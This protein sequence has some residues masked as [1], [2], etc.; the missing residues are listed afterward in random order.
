M[1]AMTFQL[2][3]VSITYGHLPTLVEV[4]LSFNGSNTVLFEG[5]TGAGKTTLVQLLTASVVPIHGV[6]LINGIPTSR[7]QPKAR[8]MFRRTLGIVPQ[9]IHL[10]ETL[11]ITQNVLAALTIRGVPKADAQRRTLEILAEFH[12]SHLREQRPQHLSGGERQLATIAVA[13]APEPK[14]LFADEPLSMLDASV[15][16]TVVHAIERR[17]SNG[18]GAVISTHDAIWS[19]AFPTATRFTVMSGSVRQAA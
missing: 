2:Q 14:L 19:S 3:D 16:D 9:H 7:M 8:Q 11:T 17:V 18:M 4:T 1:Q 13:L 10:L 5:P 12:L 15:V 6:V